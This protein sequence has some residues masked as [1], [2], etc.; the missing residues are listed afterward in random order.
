MQLVAIHYNNYINT[1][2]WHDPSRTDGSASEIPCF[3]IKGLFT[4]LFK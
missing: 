1:P 4:A 2:N 3:S